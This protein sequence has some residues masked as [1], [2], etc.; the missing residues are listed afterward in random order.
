MVMVSL[1]FPVVP[2]V[3]TK[4]KK[5]IGISTF[6]SRKCVP[7]NA[8]VIFYGIVLP[9]D[10]I[11]I[12]GLSLLVITVWNIGNVV[13]LRS[14]IIYIYFLDTFVH[15]FKLQK[16]R[17]QRKPLPRGLRVKSSVVKL[18]LMIVHYLVIGFYT[19]TASTVILRNFRDYEKVLSDHFMCEALG[20]ETMHCSRE[21][22]GKLQRDSFVQL[23]TYIC[24]NIYPSIFF[25]FF[26]NPTFCTGPIN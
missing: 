22:F 24:F 26:I 3:V 19:L 11:I 5:G 15:T 17:L 25:I 20:D 10:V 16:K 13:S 18:I 9:I 7:L 6:L 21:G 14:I 23:F 1:T 2:L 4:F 8:D 12:L